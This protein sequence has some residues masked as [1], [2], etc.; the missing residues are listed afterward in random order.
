MELW[1]LIVEGAY[2]R[3]AGELEQQYTNEYGEE[4]T[5]QDK[6]DFWRTHIPEAAGRPEVTNFLLAQQQLQLATLEN[7]EE[8][9][10]LMGDLVDWRQR[11]LLDWL[12]QFPGV[13]PTLAPRE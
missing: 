7:L 2:R 1:S 4:V 12:L 8:G 5:L 11:D 9:E 13:S 10:I 6:I 3:A